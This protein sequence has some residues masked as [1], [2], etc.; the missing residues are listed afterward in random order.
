MG[1]GCEK[2]IKT[3]Q[4]VT[5]TQVKPGCKINHRSPPVSFPRGGFHCFTHI[6]EHARREVCAGVST[7]F[8]TCRIPPCRAHGAHLSV[9]NVQEYHTG[10]QHDALINR[11]RTDDHLAQ[12][13]LS[14]LV[15]SGKTLRLSNLFSL[16]TGRTGVTLRRVA[17]TLSHLWE[18]EGLYAPH[19][20]Y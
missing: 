13:S 20:S 8:S 16:F 6:G 2:V 9:I 3:E 15:L 19:P 10:G 12:R 11:V 14:L 17:H 5:E 4:K 7:T 1:S 18:Q